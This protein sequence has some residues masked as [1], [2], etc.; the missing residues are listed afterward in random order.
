VRVRGIRK[1]D[2]PVAICR[3]EGIEGKR[4]KGE[5]CVRCSETT[6]TVKGER[7][8]HISW[9]EERTLLYLS[10]IFQCFHNV[11]A[12]IYTN[13]ISSSLK[14]ATYTISIFQFG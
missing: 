7:C 10:P 8:Y 9:E 5:R 3:G 13:A 11:R 12:S 1:S 2:E 14:D 6:Y 4:S